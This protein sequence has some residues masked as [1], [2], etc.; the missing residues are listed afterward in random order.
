M[1]KHL[2]HGDPNDRSFH[3]KNQKIT[4]NEKSASFFQMS[5]IL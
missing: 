4:I 5:Q 1:P 3:K 2:Y